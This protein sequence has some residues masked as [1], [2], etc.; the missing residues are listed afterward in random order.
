MDVLYGLTKDFVFKE[1][2]AFLKGK[3]TLTSE[4]YKMLSDE[5]R[6]KAFT[7]SGYTSLEVLQ[8]FLD[9]LTKAAEEG[10]TKEQ[11]L[12]DMNR[13]LEEH[14]YEG[15]NP[16]KCDKTYSGQGM[17]EWLLHAAMKCSRYMELIEGSPGMKEN[18]QRT[19]AQG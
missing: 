10:T 8:E 15:I 6:A 3:R 1:A 19:S 14:G 7:V 9:C 13:F 18:I 17:R 11:F 12:E 4:E 5:S 2:V 16:W